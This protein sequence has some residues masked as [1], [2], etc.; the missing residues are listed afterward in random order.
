M[1]WKC[2][3]VLIVATVCFA[4]TVNYKDCGSVSGTIYSIDVTPC[5][6]E[7]CTLHANTNY[8]VHINFTS[9]V[10]SKTAK[11]LVHGIIAGVPV[12]FPV[13]V[14]CC[15][16]NNMRCPIVAGYNDIYSNTIF[17]SPDYPKIRLV[18]K[19]EV[20]DDNGLDI[21]CYEIP[22]QIS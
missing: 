2:A 16:N 10:N 14:D 11:N 17:C 18:M 15:E 5:D 20:Q 22:L 13:P 19:W 7:P 21:M 1:T 6:V 4:K 9:K 12:P 3:L 8:S